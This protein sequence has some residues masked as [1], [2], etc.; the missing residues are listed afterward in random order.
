MVLRWTTLGLMG[1]VLL[2]ACAQ[3]DPTRTPTVALTPTAPP[4]G[5]GT[6][7]ELIALMGC[8][9]CHTIDSVPGARGQIGPDL[10]HIGGR[11][12]AAYIRESIIDPNA[13]IASGCPAFDCQPGVMPPTLGAAM[14]SEELDALVGYLASLR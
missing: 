2:A 5:A 3:P 12:D 13:I 10:S 1:A 8:S 9:G 7:P 14:T 4:A 6:G 11:A